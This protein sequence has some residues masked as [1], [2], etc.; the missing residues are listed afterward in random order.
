[1]G[2]LTLTYELRGSG[3]A[4]A[5]ISDERASVTL[6][7]SYLSDALGDLA[8]A[9]LALMRGADRSRFAWAEEP[10]EYRWLL[11]RQGADLQITVLWFRDTFSRQGDE[12]GGVVFRSQCSL[13]RFA[14]QVHGLLLRLLDDWGVEG[15]AR[16]WKNHEFPLAAHERLTALLRE[17]RR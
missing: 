11:A 17:R 7:A 9:T 10:G 15:Y 6:T 13:V 12:Q 4:E 8:D 2:K 1:M 3:T 5:V 14:G 16:Q